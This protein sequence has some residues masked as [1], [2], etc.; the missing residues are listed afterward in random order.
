MHR[1]FFELPA[2]A[3]RGRLGCIYPPKTDSPWC[4]KAANIFFELVSGKMLVAKA[5]LVDEEV[6]TTF[7]EFL[8]F[9]LK[10]QC[11]NQFFLTLRKFK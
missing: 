11:L 4:V 5:T 9:T 3:I 1:Q 7:I 6:S 10:L 8:G 2:Q